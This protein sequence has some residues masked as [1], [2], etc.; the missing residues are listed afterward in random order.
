MLIIS[1]LIS[2]IDIVLIFLFASKLVNKPAYLDLKRVAIGIGYGLAMGTLVHFT[3]GENQ[4]HQVIGVVID[5]ILIYKITKRRY[6][7]IILAYGTFVIALTIIQL[8]LIILLEA[9]FVEEQTFFLVGQLLSLAIMVLIYWKAPLSKLYRFIEKQYWLQLVTVVIA[10][11]SV[12]AAFYWNFTFSILSVLTVTFF[13]V[14]MLIVVYKIGRKIVHL[15]YTIPSK[16]HDFRNRIHGKMLKAYQEEDHMRIAFYHEIYEENGFQIEANKL[17]L[18]KTT[19]NIVSF[20]E[21]KKEDHGFYDEIIY[22]INYYK[23]H[24]NV[25]INVIIKCMGILLDN[26]LESGTN[27]PVIVE[28]DV[29]MGHI[30]LYVRN[31]F[32]LTDPEAIERIFTGEGYTTKKT[33]GRGYGISNLHREVT[34]HGGKIVDSYGYNEVGKTYYLTVGVEF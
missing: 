32:E 17:H 26:A 7:G 19:E 28:L 6:I 25:G 23:D 34:K 10:F 5:L 8:P 4:M 14:T 18:G 33:N 12:I 16:M 1:M 24:L 31:E 3:F 9:S 30:H 27:K 20:I 21:M 29:G 22:D 15:T 11:L 13:F 2:L